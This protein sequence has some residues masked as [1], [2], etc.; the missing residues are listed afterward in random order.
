MFMGEYNHTVDEKG[1]LIIPSKFREQLGSEF[2][3]TK[4][5]DGGLFAFAM[6]EWTEFETKLRALPLTNKNART[7]AR[8]MLSGAATVEF[9]KMG[10]VLIPQNLRSFA[11]LEKEVTLIGVS[12][13]FEIWNRDIWEAASEVS[14]IEELAENMESL[15]I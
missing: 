6:E 10:R 15:G 1:R 4:G 13:R 11:K 9:D 2:V 8:Y 14:N 12:G 3:I 7:F 5:L